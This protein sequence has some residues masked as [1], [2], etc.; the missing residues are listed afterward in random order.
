MAKGNEVQDHWLTLLVANLYLEAQAERH[1]YLSLLVRY[2][3]ASGR[4]WARL[5]RSLLRS[6]WHLSLR[7]GQNLCPWQAVGILRMGCKRGGVGSGGVRRWHGLGVCR[8]GQLVSDFRKGK[9]MLWV[10]FLI[11]ILFFSA[12][13]IEPLALLIWVRGQQLSQTSGKIVLPLLLQTQNNLWLPEISSLLWA[14]LPRCNQGVTS[15]EKIA[16]LLPEAATW[17]TRFLKHQG[18]R[19][20]R[21]EATILTGCHRASVWTLPGAESCGEC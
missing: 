17:N 9:R 6:L 8:G 21:A 18:R 12:M 13:G 3:W 11:I 16:V 14:C 7:W 5:T 15:G 4:L 10:F 19:H 20:L 1:T 2:I